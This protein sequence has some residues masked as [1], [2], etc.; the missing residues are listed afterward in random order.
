MKRLYPRKA[1]IARA[2]EAAKACGIDVGGI[3]ISPDGWIRVLGVGRLSG[4]HGE[5]DKWDKAGLL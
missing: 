3:E 4:T 5:Y 1:E 2:V